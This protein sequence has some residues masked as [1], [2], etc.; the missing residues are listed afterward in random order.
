MDAS[1]AAAG[2]R[3]AGLLDFVAPELQR[4]L[5][6]LRN[7]VAPACFSR[8]QSASESIDICIELLPFPTQKGSLLAW[9]LAARQW[10]RTSKWTQ[11]ALPCADM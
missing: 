7:Q 11:P 2:S 9:H 3:P 1:G 6:A 10:V 8:G 5:D 4:Q